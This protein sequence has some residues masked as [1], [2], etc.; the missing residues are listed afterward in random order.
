MSGL[1]NLVNGFNPACIII[2]PM[3]GRR[4]T[5]Y[6]RFRD[7]FVSD[8]HEHILIYTRVGG[9]NRGCGFGEEELMKDPNF[10][11]TYDDDYDN[12]YGYYEF[13]VP[14]HWKSDFD[15]IIANDLAK[16]SDKYVNYVKAFYPSLAQNGL[17]DGLF[18][19][20]RKEE[21]GESTD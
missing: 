9:N 8:D 19:R 21:D 17:I 18:E 6:P 10:V 11:K 2:M 16:V 20:E 15:L 5:D 13:N 4:E 7:C 14:E 3:L 12:T 1:Y